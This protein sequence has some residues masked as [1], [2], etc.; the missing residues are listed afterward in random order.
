MQFF[1]NWICEHF[2][3]VNKHRDD[4]ESRGKHS[5]YNEQ[6]IK[7]FRTINLDL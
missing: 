6:R 3:I 2:H 1:N 7:P 5:Q 4:T